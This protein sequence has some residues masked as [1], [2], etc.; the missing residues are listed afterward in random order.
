MIC[1]NSGILNG[2]PRVIAGS[3]LSDH[4]NVSR[5]C[6][7][8]RDTGQMINM[9]VLF[10]VGNWHFICSVITDSFNST[11]IPW[12]SASNVT[13]WCLEGRGCILNDVGGGKVLLD[14]YGKEYDVLALHE[15]PSYGWNNVSTRHRWADIFIARRQG[16]EGQMGSTTNPMATCSTWRGMCSVRFYLARDSLYNEKK[17]A[18]II[19][20][21]AARV[22]KDSAFH[23]T[24]GRR[25]QICYWCII[26]DSR[27]RQHHHRHME[28]KDTKSCGK[29][30]GTSTRNGQVHGTSLDSMK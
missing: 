28:H 30:P 22:N 23:P 3:R 5:K 19:G 20:S 18:Y 6:P 16:T 29:T 24:P 4:Y 7:S 10:V 2:F 17:Q 14:L 13:H 8:T 21:V 12:Q 27:T 26:E 25:C 9:H 1:N 11:S 15:S